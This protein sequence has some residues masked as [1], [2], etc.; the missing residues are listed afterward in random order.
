MGDH[1]IIYKEDRDFPSLQDIDIALIG[2][3]EDRSAI[4]NE[5]C[6]LAA[7]YVRSY[8]YNLFP[9]HPGMRIAD[10]GNIVRGNNPEDTYFA[11]TALLGELMAKGIV[12][13]IIGGSQELTYAAYQAYKN[14]NRIMN[15]VAVDNKFDIGE[16][17]GSLNS[18]SYL[19]HIIL[20]KP[21]YLFNYANIGYQTYLVDQDA[22]NLV[23]NLYFDSIRLGIVQGNL[24]NIEPVIR[25][26]DMLS[27][28]VSA[29]RQSDAPGN[30]NATPNGFYGEEACQ[31][32]RY[33]GLSDKLSCIGFYELN[34]AFD[35]NGQTAHLLAQ[36]IWYFIDGY[37]NRDAENPLTHKE[38]FTM[39]N[40]QLNHFSDGIQFY[41][42]NKT[43]RWWMEVN[44]SDQAKEKFVNH[45]MVPCSYEDYQTACKD[46][47]PDRWWQA[48]QKLM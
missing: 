43:D 1:F 38:D 31:I 4:G 14:R 44:C 23:R 42:S 29:I 24:S 47:M 32:A 12:T 19:S 6:G 15:L 26:A 30:G 39:Y 45:Y 46:E 8:L 16:S 17:E 9:S 2:V 10:L 18:H 11:L 5:G 34:P 28:D 7:D 27:F 35:R 40:V 22:I 33:C 48:Y 3:N 37:Y 36:M 20:H 41:R 21:N 25:N 13:V